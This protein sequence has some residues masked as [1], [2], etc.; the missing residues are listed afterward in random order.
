MVPLH[1]AGGGVVLRGEAKPDTNSADINIADATVST[2]VSQVAILT[3]TGDDGKKALRS[4]PMWL[5]RDAAALVN[6]ETRHVY[7][8]INLQ[9]Q[10]TPQEKEAYSQGRYWFVEVADALIGTK[11]GEMLL[12]VDLV[13]TDPAFYSN[14]DLK[15]YRSGNEPPSDAQS[16][17][18]SSSRRAALEKYRERRIHLGTGGNWTWSDA[19][20]NYTFRLD[21]QNEKL[22]IRGRPNFTFLE[23]DE[24]NPTNA[25][26]E[27]KSA[28]EVIL[29][30]TRE[31][32][33]ELS[34]ALQRYGH[35]AGNGAAASSALEEAISNLNGFTNLL[36]SSLKHLRSATNG[37]Q[38]SS[39]QSALEDLLSEE[40]LYSRLRR[41]MT[42][43]ASLDV[44]ARTLIIGT[45]NLLKSATAQFNSITNRFPQLAGGTS[46]IWKENEISTE[47]FSAYPKYIDNLNPEV[48][49]NSVEFGRVAAFFRYLKSHKPAAWSKVYSATTQFPPS[50]GRTPRLIERELD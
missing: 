7:R 36:G 37:L 39:T 15:Y 47:Y 18:R 5:V 24:D 4:A 21:G 49:S 44:Q 27:A 9:G 30:K 28:A 3:I 14:Y 13:Q 32:S 26:I 11:S 16:Q 46:A 6:S 31:S 29:E 35:L 19:D 8:A 17:T 42:N 48:F 22:S 1:L 23:I 12:V 25:L 50:V 45:S 2:N 41:N 20:A 40:F 38:H 34:T 33:F 43:N 10:P